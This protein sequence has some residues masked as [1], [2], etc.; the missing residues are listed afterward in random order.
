MRAAGIPKRIKP[1]KLSEEVW[2][3]RLQKAKKQSGTRQSRKAR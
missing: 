2:E 3:E 1:A